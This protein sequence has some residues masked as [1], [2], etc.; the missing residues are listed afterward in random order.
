MWELGRTRILGE[1]S[2]WDELLVSRIYV[3]RPS[4]SLSVNI[5]MTNP[6]E[7]DIFKDVLLC[8]PYK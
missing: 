3:R 5:D 1:N 4:G 7:L 8:G 6:R 2:I